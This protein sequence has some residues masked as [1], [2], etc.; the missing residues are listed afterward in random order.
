[1][2]KALE[3]VAAERARQVEIG[4]TSEHDDEHGVGHLANRAVVYASAGRYTGIL[5]PA[6][7][8]AQLVKGAAMLVAAIER[9]DRAADVEI[10]RQSNG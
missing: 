4:W 7:L 8:R 10:R 9:V 5:E 2:S 1:M 3:D 6:L